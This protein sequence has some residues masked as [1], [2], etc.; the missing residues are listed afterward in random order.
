MPPKRVRAQKKKKQSEP[1]PENSGDEWESDSNRPAKKAK[2]TP[3]VQK[4]QATKVAIIKTNSE[5]TQ[6]VPATNQLKRHSLKDFRS[7]PRANTELFERLNLFP[8][9]PPVIIPEE[10]PLT[11]KFEDLWKDHVPLPAPRYLVGKLGDIAVPDIYFGDMAPTPRWR[12]ICKSS[13]SQ[14]WLPVSV[15]SSPRSS[16]DKISNS[17]TSSGIYDWTWVFEAGDFWSWKRLEYDQLYEYAYL[18]LYQTLKEDGFQQE[19]IRHAVFGPLKLPVIPPHQL[20]PG[21]PERPGTGWFNLDNNL[22]SILK[23]P[24]REHDSFYYFPDYKRPTLAIRPDKTGIGHMSTH[25]IPQTM[26]N[27][28][29]KSLSST[30]V[31]SWERN[32]WEQ[33]VSPDSNAE[34]NRWG[35]QESG[36]QKKSDQGKA[37]PAKER[38][39]ERNEE[40]KTA[41]F[42]EYRF[43]WFGVILLVLSMFLCLFL[44]VFKVFTP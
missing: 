26:F 23:R 38:D 18:C 25:V 14:S 31:N 34:S 19:R 17:S 16:G 11:L 40:G 41:R 13:P 21:L 32:S 2:T 12:V 8:C 7:G 20:L 37:D 10:Q 1:P 27:L 24:P 33:S 3:N 29:H 9:P 6:K 15:S 43:V 42:G 28:M 30:R 22:S 36:D 39:L 35:I 44:Y 4:T 5:A